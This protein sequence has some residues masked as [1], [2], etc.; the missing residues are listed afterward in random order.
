MTNPEY[1]IVT[2]HWL[3]PKS[4]DGWLDVSEFES[5]EPASCVTTGYLITDGTTDGVVR[6]C[7]TISDDKGVG[8]GISI[9]L[10]C[11]LRP[12]HLPRDE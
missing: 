10:G 12:I 11:L 6:V 2:V 1:P 9:P 4:V 3:D 7:A 5:L 8:D